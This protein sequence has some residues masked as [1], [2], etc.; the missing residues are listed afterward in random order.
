MMEAAAGAPDQDS[1][2][3]ISNWPEEMIL[4]LFS[5]LSRKD[6]VK[7]SEVNKRF[8]D[9]SRDGSLWP[10]KLTLDIGDFEQ[11][12]ASCIGLVERCTKLATL[13]ISNKSGLWNLP[14]DTTMTVVIGAKESLKSLEIDS[15]MRRWTPAAMAQLGRMKNLTLLTMTFYSDESDRFAGVEML[16]EIGKL[17]NLEELDLNIIS[18]TNTNILPTMKIVF[19]NLKKLRNV[20]I[21]LPDCAYDESLVDTLAKNNP[22]LTGIHFLNYHSLSDK[23]IDFLASSCPGL[24]G[25]NID[26]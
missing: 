14:L 22:D 15:F 17:D 23:C 21:N 18:R 3:N 7:I 13:K 8:R 9:L 25:L 4:L 1:I 16:E 20:K 11:K 10:V 5:Y 19:Q 6:L 26:F 12:T 24:Q 2:I